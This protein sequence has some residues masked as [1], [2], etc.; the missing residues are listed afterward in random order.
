MRRVNTEPNSLLDR[1]RADEEA[2]EL[3]KRLQLEMDLH[4]KTFAQ[5]KD[6]ERR[7][8][9]ANAKG[10]SPKGKKFGCNR[11]GVYEPPPFDPSQVQSTKP[12]SP[13]RGVYLPTLRTIPQKTSPPPREGQEVIS[14]TKEQLHPDRM[15]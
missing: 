13:K 15:A 12:R 4:E 11:P 10:K 1:T 6:L 14:Q 3:K 9:L 7:L 5:M 8:K 2:A